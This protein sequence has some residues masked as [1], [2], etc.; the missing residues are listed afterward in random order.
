[1]DI[2]RSSGLILHPTS[3]PSNFGI[4]DLGDSSFEFIDMLSS[5]GT[6]VWQ[7]LPLGITDNVEYSPYSSKSS[8]LGNPYIVSLENLEN[9]I[10]ETEDIEVFKKLPINFVDYENVYKLKNNLFEKLAKK[11]NINE[12]SYENFL[13]NEDIRK[14]ITFITISEAHKKDWNYWEKEFKNYSDNLFELVIEKYPEIIK[15]HVFLQYEFN[16]Q[17]QKLKQYANKQNISV[18]GDIPIYVNHN[19]ADVWLNKSL[20]D[21]DDNNKMGFVSGA[22]PDDFTKEGQ[23][24]NTALYEWDK[25]RKQNYQYWV[26]KLNNNLEKYDLLRIDHFIGFFKFW[27]IPYGESALKG[28][29]RSGPW[30][31][32]FKSISNEVDFSKLLAEDLGVELKETDRTLNDYNIPGMKVLQQR[33]PNNDGHNEVHPKHWKE[34]VVAYTGTHDSPT[35]KQWFSESDEQ[36]IKFYNNYLNSLNISNESDVWNFIELTWRTPS[37]LAITNAQDILELGM[38]ARFNLPGT[39]K[40]NWKWRVG[41]L[42]ALQEGLVK[43][44]KLNEDTSR[45]NSLT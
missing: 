5:S 44:K 45:L 33:I 25:H 12:K 34:N 14:H 13:K 28:H 7:V 2:K 35:V 20:F 1:M 41:A 42:D 37:I 15:K 40:S 36:Q 29:W 18:L 38:G 39:Q 3:L 27:A 11:I 9:N 10:L 6:K 26:S 16:N 19:S 30:E 31:T 22:V 43:L 17:W 8:I 32:F 23:V 4:G 21:L 24:W